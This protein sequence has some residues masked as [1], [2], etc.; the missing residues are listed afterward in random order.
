M[1]RHGQTSVAAILLT[2][3]A[4]NGRGS[5]SA[6]Q[7]VP[8]SSPFENPADVRFGK[9]T[10]IRQE[11]EVTFANDTWCVYG[12]IV[13]MKP[14]CDGE[15]CRATLYT[16]EVGGSPGA[17]LS[18]DAQYVA[19]ALCDSL[20]LRGDST[21]VGVTNETLDVAFYKKAADGRITEGTVSAVVTGVLRVQDT[22]E[23]QVTAD[24]PGEPTLR[25][26]AAWDP[27]P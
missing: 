13:T 14:S 25:G 1:N 18:S 27:L 5:Y 12:S 7:C 4:C 22:I 16:L 21:A 6:D 2:L 20:E 23:L 26:D 19:I 10:K 3:A 15:L 17:C 11:S 24:I 8:R 9:A